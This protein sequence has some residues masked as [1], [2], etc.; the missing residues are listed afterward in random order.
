MKRTGL[1]KTL[2]LGLAAI[3]IAFITW[4]GMQFVTQTG[5]F[6][7]PGVVVFDESLLDTEIDA[8]ELYFTEE[9]VLDKDVLIS[10]YN[11]L[12]RPE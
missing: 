9:V 5:I 7:V 6:K 11:T 10:A 2:L 12:T 3:A 4:L 8:L 1:K